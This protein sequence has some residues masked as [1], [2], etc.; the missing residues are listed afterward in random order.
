M[1][2]RPASADRSISTKTRDFITAEN[3][4]SAV[5]QCSTEPSGV[6]HQYSCLEIAGLVKHV[7]E[8]FEAIGPSGGRRRAPSGRVVAAIP[9]D[10]RR[11][12]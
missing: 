9:A 2:R 10:N 7:I 1:G 5:L 11:G 8:D 3:R 6:D 12:V 4:C